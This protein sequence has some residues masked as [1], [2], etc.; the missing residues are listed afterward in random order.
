MAILGA[1]VGSIFAGPF[2]DRYGRKP[3]IIMADLLFMLGAVVM[4]SAPN[5]PI[6]IVGRLIVG[7]GVG[8][9]SMIVPIYLSESS[10]T[11]IRGKLVT[12]NVLMITTGQFISYLVC[13]ALGDKW[14]WMLG[15]AGVPALL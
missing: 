11:E 2:S 14:R 13:I 10:P 1:A 15:L 9:A 5:I 4:A 7:F 3:T 6:L 8:I 12:C